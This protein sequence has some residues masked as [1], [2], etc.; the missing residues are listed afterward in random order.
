[1]VRVLEVA[2]SVGGDLA[3]ESRWAK[4]WRLGIAA[5]PVTFDA[6]GRST[7]RLLSSLLGSRRER[8]VSV[9]ALLAEENLRLVLW[10]WRL[11]LS[12]ESTMG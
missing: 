9:P 11:G 3:E 2:C 12:S 10:L 1:M 4:E 5:A 8:S 7:L 6:L